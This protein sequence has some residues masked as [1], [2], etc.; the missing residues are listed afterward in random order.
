MKF[1]RDE[2]R[3]VC[4]I[5]APSV[6][7]AYL[8]ICVCVRLHFSGCVVVVCPGAGSTQ[9]DSMGGEAY[10]N[11]CHGLWIVTFLLWGPPAG[12]SA[13][14]AAEPDPRLSRHTCDV[15]LCS[16]AL[17][18]RSGISIETRIAGVIPHPQKFIIV[19]MSVAEINRNKY[20][21]LHEW[22]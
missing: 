7:F 17:R 12:V 9:L 19:S 18:T 21:F 10:H 20:S 11:V 4:P 2:V 8:C 13:F 14:I 5:C 22:H 1:I 15:R 3:S 16:G 6:Q